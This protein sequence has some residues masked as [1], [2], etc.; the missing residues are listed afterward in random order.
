MR[1]LKKTTQKEKLRDALFFR[2]V[3]LFLLAWRRLWGR[4]PPRYKGELQRPGPREFAVPPSPTA[5]F[6]IIPCSVSP[7]SLW[8]VNG[9][10]EA[11]EGWMIPPAEAAKDVGVRE[12]IR[13][14]SR[15][16]KNWSLELEPG[17]PPRCRGCVAYQHELSNRS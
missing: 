9:P 11:G 14:R 16:W 12:K 6:S 1:R 2:C 8:L 5:P 15:A 7:T 10:A 3:I 13:A 4:P 17:F